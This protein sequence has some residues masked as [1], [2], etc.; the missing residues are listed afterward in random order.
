MRPNSILSKSFTCARPSARGFHVSTLLL[1]PASAFASLIAVQELDEPTVQGHGLHTSATHGPIHFS[2]PLV[3]ESPSPDTKVRFGFAQFD[4]DGDEE[5]GTETEFEFEAEYAFHPSS[6]I[7]AGVPYVSLDPD[8]SSSELGIGNAELAFKFAFAG[9]GLLLGY[10]LELG[11]PTGDE[12]KGIGSNREL[13]FEPLF[14][15]G[16]K[17]E[18]LELVL[19]TSFGIPTNQGEN[20][21]VETELGFDVS[22]LCHFGERFMGLLELDGETGPS[23]D[24]SG[25]TVLNLSPGPKFV[26]GRNRDQNIGVGVGFPLSDTEEF[27]T[28][29]L[30]SVSRHF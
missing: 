19:F 26:P 27:E 28:R 25:E 5:S 30:V 29:A 16:C 12:S 21:E 4:I 24:E 17:Q 1:L 8:E 22:A 11:L 13:E 3:A 2:H 9:Q 10:G 7:E 14:N 15:L 20:E 6:S 18:E 23:G